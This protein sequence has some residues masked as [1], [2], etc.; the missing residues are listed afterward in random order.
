MIQQSSAVTHQIMTSHTTWWRPTQHDDVTAFLSGSLIVYLRVL[1]HNFCLHNAGYVFLTTHMNAQIGFARSS[2]VAQQTNI[3]LFLHG[4][5][6]H[7]FM[8]VHATRGPERA[9]FAMIKSALRVCPHVYHQVTTVIWPVV[10]D[11]T[12][13]RFFSRVFPDVLHVIHLVERGEVAEG[14]VECFAAWYAWWVHPG[15]GR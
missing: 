2:I 1:S 10:A 9:Q 15:V 7:M 5:R 3:R 14:A 12:R 6:L 4:M 8:E 11:L 13:V